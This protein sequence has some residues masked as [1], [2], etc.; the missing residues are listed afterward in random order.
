M[1]RRL[2]FLG[3]SI[4]VVSA[5]AFAQA[6][7]QVGG[8]KLASCEKLCPDIPAVTCHIDRALYLL[9]GW[10]AAM[11]PCVEA[12]MHSHK[13]LVRSISGIL[14]GIQELNESTAIAS[15]K[16]LTKFQLYEAAAQ[17]ELAH[18]Y[19]DAGDTQSANE[20]LQQAA[21]RYLTLFKTMEK[22]PDFPAT[23]HKIAS[24]LIRAGRPVDALTVLSRLPPDDSERLYLWAESL[25]SMGARAAAAMAY[26]QWI[27]A[28]CQSDLAM[29]AD[30]EF[31]PAFTFLVFPGPTNQNKCERMP[32]E[33]RGRLRGLQG[34]FFHPNNIPAKNTPSTPFPAR[35]GF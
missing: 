21:E 5:S 2:V 8:E 20:A 6:P 29:L 24:G 10:D 25:F 17:V 35:E 1:M 26:E 28:G 30:D 23:G 7:P 22:F 12:E 19:I 31:G 15:G 4:L 18:A 11:S 32:E 14:L 9:R 33:L 27:A 13:N 16:D 34:E 3:V